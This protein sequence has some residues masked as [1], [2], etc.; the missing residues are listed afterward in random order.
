MNVKKPTLLP[1]RVGFCIKNSL[2]NL[3]VRDWRGKLV[4][5]NLRFC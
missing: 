3:N 1:W 4:E 2:R 5:C